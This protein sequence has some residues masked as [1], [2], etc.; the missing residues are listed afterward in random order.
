M[1]TALQGK[2][3]LVTGAARRIGRAIALELAR[4]GVSPIL[5]YRASEAEAG[6]VA[7]EAAGFGVEPYLLCADLSDREA[8]NDLAQ[9]AFGILGPVDFLVNSAAI[10]PESGVL[11][12][13]WE[14]LAECLQVN[15]YAP[16]SLARAFAAQ[17]HGGAIVNVLDA[18]IADYD[19]AHAAYHLSKRTLSTLT[20]MLARELAPGIRVNA[21]APG[22]ILPPEGREEALRGSNP[23]ERIG[24]V[25]EVAEAVRYL[26]TAEFVTGEV[27]YVDGGRHLRGGMYS[28]A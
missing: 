21:V 1:G 17:G 22:V 26:L 28:G 8:V 18:R 11:D 14:E 2:K 3:A 4:A 13:A 23:L 5:H 10:Y 19:A 20:R 27:L 24:T 9:S 7:R 15:T 25:E 12:F 16:L 6:Q